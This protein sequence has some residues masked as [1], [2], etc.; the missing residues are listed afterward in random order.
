MTNLFI[1]FFFFFLLVF[2]WSYCFLGYDSPFLSM[3]VQLCI[4]NLPPP[5]FPPSL[6]SI[7]ALPPPFLLLF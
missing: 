3:Y 5:S 4:S 2:S 6:Q 1:F 7:D